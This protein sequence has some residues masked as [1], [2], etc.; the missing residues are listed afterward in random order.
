MPALR[1]LELVGLDASVMNVYPIELSGGMKKRV[2]LARALIGSPKIL[3]L[4][5]PTSGLDPIMAAVVND[6]IC[7]C[8]K[9]FNL[10]VTTVD[11]KSDHFMRYDMNLMLFVLTFSF[12]HYSYWSDGKIGPCLNQHGW[13]LRCSYTISKDESAYHQG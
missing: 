2:A 8:H 9:E 3:V 6:I 12:L 10:C 5:E 13:K 11:T 4:D 7:R 1:G